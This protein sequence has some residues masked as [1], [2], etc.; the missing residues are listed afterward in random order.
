[1]LVSD[2][3]IQ[4]IKNQ[5]L[6]MASARV[7]VGA[8]QATQEMM[9]AQALQRQ[10]DARIDIAHQTSLEAAR[11]SAIAAKATEAQRIAESK[12]EQ[13]WGKIQQAEQRILETESAAYFN[14][15]ASR[16]LG[17]MGACKTDPV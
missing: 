5:E 2:V 12:I 1:M 17:R 7:I 10:A 8:E 3:Q 9:N 11:T 15:A 6:S 13:A 4:E 14:L 16:N